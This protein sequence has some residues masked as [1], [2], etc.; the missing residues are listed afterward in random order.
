M[1]EEFV[2]YKFTST[3]ETEAIAEEKRLIAKLNDFAERTG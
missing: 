3:S 2:K 1:R